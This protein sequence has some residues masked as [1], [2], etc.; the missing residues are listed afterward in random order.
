MA[1]DVIVLT[2]SFAAKKYYK[3]SALYGA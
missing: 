1:I 2:R 3:K